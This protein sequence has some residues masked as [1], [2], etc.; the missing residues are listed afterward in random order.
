MDQLTATNKYNQFHKPSRVLTNTLRRM[1]L[2]METME[3][4]HRRGTKVKMDPPL[5]HAQLMV[6]VAKALE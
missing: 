1:L 4:L 2:L 6:L 5:A 3:R